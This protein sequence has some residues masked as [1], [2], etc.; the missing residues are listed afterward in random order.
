M[1]IFPSS[2]QLNSAHWYTPD[3]K[4]FHHIEENGRVRVT[5][6]RDARKYSLY[7]SVTSIL[8]ILSK[9][10]LEK[11]KLRQIT[12][13]AFNNPSIQLEEK[14][15]DS[16]NS[17]VIGMAFLKVHDAANLGSRIHHEL[18]VCTKGKECSD[19]EIAK[20]IQGFLDWQKDKDIRFTD[21]ETVVVNK[22]HGFAGRVDAFFQYGKEG[23]GILDYKTRKFDKDEQPA[24][25]DNEVLQLGAYAATYYAEN[26]LCS[27]LA[28]NAYISST[29]PGA[30]HIHKH[31]CLQEAWE[32]FKSLCD[33]WRYQMKYDPREVING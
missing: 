14:T 7:P 28:G 25:Y 1:A 4:P 10:G 15:A 3:G 19:K 9:P 16:Y 5:T 21:T 12:D 27:V 20:Y 33:V 11:W 18:D 23:I 2:Q 6:L 31:D 17:K 29:C 13:V 32:A 22:E 26:K 30:F 8:N 24:T